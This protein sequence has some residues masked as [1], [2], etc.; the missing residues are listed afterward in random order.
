M[1][2]YTAAVFA[3]LVG[4]MGGAGVG[5]FVGVLLAGGAHRRPGGPSR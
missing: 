3:V 5:F 2:S 4:M 1:I